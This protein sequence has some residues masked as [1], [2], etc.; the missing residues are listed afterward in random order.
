[1]KFAILSFGNYEYDGRL[2]ELYKAF[3]SLGDTYLLSHGYNKVSDKHCII[4]TKNYF[5]FVRKSVQWL[6]KV[7]CSE[8]I[9]VIVLDDRKS[10]IPGLICKHKY[11]ND[12]IFIEDCRELYDIKDVKHLVGKIGC[13]FEKK[14]IEKADIIICANNERASAMMKMFSLEKRPIVFENIRQLSFSDD[15]NLDMIKEKYSSYINEGE[16]RIISTSGCSLSNTNDILVKNLK[17]VSPQYKIRLFLVGDDKS[18]DYLSMKKLLLNEKK[19]NIDILGKLNQNDLKY[20]IQQSHIGIVNYAQ[21][22]LCSRLCASGK[23]YEFIFENIP[24]VTTENLPLK[25]LC[26]KFN[27]GV[28]D[29]QYYKGINKVLG[30]YTFYKKCVSEFKK[31]HTVENNIKLFSSNIKKEIRALSS[32]R[33]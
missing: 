6:N 18:Q 10:T 8:E 25:N 3:C 19:C 12:I 4:Q 23:L 15:F 32:N 16:I 27:I 17:Y 9:D 24:I 33:L 22:D 14:M 7:K 1:M 21:K 20:L 30:D 28:A 29:N 13:F 31:D 11:K 26:E 2:R 5:D